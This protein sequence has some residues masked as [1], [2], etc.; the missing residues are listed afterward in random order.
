MKIQ[1]ATIGLALLCA[2]GSAKAQFYQLGPN[3]GLSSSISD[4]GIV[5][6]AD[7][8][9]QE[10]YY[11]WSAGT[12][13]VNIGGASAGSGIGGQPTISNDGLYVG[14]TVFN[15][16]N[17]WYEMGRYDV[18]ADA[19]TGFGAL[20]GIG[21]QS[22]VS[23]GSGWAISGNGQTVG[24]LA[25]TNQGTGDGYG[26]LY[27]SGTGWNN[28]GTNQVGWSTRVN[29]LNG[30]GQVAAGWQ[31]GDEGRQG[32]VWNNGTQQLIFNHIG[33]IAQ[34]AHAVSDNGAFATG[35]GIGRGIAPGNAYR[36]DIIT[37]SYEEIPNLLIDAGR[38]MSGTAIN[39]DGTLIG[40]GT[41][42][43]GPA[44]F[45]TAFIWEE[46]VGTMTVGD[47][48]DSKGASYDADFHFSFVSGMSSDG[49]WL[50]GWGYNEADGLG[51][52]QSYGQSMLFQHRWGLRCLGWQGWQQLAVNE[53][54]IPYVYLL[55]LKAAHN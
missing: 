6:G 11:M 43:N 54:N 49:E 17:N 27:N 28:L 51:A 1:T 29:G 44:S 13:A 20:P 40:G 38:R 25:Q 19:W 18:L 24:G 31:D 30:N 48:L 5:V 55:F 36:Y 41:W 53:N 8:N 26:A 9:G 32:A 33:M 39:G 45:G 46:G 4:N 16:T 7:V 47:Y 50:T 2:A 12:G 35:M 23:V 3:A 22:D 10:N 21:Q 15:S 37:D 42:N 52:T 14:G 34:E